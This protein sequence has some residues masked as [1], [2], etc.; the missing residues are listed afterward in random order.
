MADNVDANIFGKSKDTQKNQ[1][2]ISIIPVLSGYEYKMDHKHRGKAIIFN[3]YKFDNNSMPVRSGTELDCDR[4]EKVLRNIY[5]FEVTVCM[6]YKY[7]QIFDTLDKAAN[8]DYT[9]CDC[10]LVAVMS[11]GEKG[12]L[13]ARDTSYRIETLWTPFT[14]CPTLIGKPKIF[15][16]QAC[17][18]DK[19]DSGH[20]IF[21]DSPQLATIPTIADILVMYSTFEGYYSFRSSSKGSWFI[22]R[23]CDE[24]ESRYGDNN[25]KDILQVLTLV[26]R[27]MALKDSSFN[28]FNKEVHNKKQVG[29]IVSSL[30]RTLY[31]KRRVLT[32]NFQ[33][34]DEPMQ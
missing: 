8:E 33:Y 7:G 34:E 15:F 11:H 1:D 17:R 19:L 30:T 10:V 6:D 9:D 32:N 16:I 18:G 28:P 22:Q 4:L 12:K 27:Q 5:D 31:L 3:H 2:S 13:Y 25:D 26:N 20:K 21:V 29:S 24:L 23:L 14:N